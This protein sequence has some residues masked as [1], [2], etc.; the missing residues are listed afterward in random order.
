MSRAVTQVSETQANKVTSINELFEAMLPAGDFGIDRDATSLLTFGYYG[1]ELV[2]DGALTTIADG[3]LSLTQSA[4][5]YVERTQAGTVS[6]NTSGFTAGRVPL[7][8]ITT[9]TTGI[10]SIVDRRPA[11]DANAGRCLVDVSG[12][13]SS[14]TLT[15]AQARCRIIELVGTLS[16]PATVTFPAIKA[17][18]IVRNNTSG[19]QTITLQSTDSG[20]PTAASVAVSDTGVSLI[21]C[22][23]SDLLQVAGGGG[24]TA[25]TGLTDT[26]SSYSGQAGKGVRVNSAESAL[27]FFDLPGRNLLINGCFRVN[28]RNSSTAAADDTYGHDR[29]YRLTQ[30]NP[31]AVST[32]TD[33]EDAL[34]YMARMTQ[35]N[36]SAQRMGYAQI[37]EG[38]NCK[39]LRGQQVSFRMR[40][41]RLSAS[42]NIR[43]AVL[44]WT[45]TEDSVT[46]DIVLDWTSASY[47]AGGFFLGSSLT[48]SGVSQQALAANTLTD[49]DELT[50]TLGS[51]FNNLLVFYWTEGTVAQNVTLDAGQIQLEPG[52]AA[53]AFE[54]RQITQ[55]QL[56]CERYLP[57]FNSGGTA[58]IFGFGG[59]NNTTRGVVQMLPKVP[60]RVAPTGITVSDSTHFSISSAGASTA[61]TSVTF[62]VSQSEHILLI[63]FDVASGLV[64]GNANF[65]FANNASGQI[66][67]TGC[68]L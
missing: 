49:G 36:A 68:E 40:R 38:K 67:V 5:N 62:N 6:A 23:G 15:A 57:A 65:A 24:A 66:L 32:L 16:A 1:G 35:S 20:S 27:V 50:V 22:N 47:T 33:V 56:L 42:A 9:T 17:F 44:E 48:V 13:P 55:E 37:I 12:S 2:V 7:Y 54:N 39:H 60:M 29:W 45:G 46:S 3:T 34:P 30:S 63:N 43:F 19:G 11:V 25:Y 53:T 4:T 58:S 51:S 26:P 31:V 52:A 61:C 21:A 41:V 8:E 14:F 18:W 28:R 59:N 10:S 64:A